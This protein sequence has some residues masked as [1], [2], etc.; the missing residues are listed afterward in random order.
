LKISFGSNL[1]VLI[2]L[3]CSSTFISGQTDAEAR[4]AQ[5]SQALVKGHVA[6]ETKLSSP[7][8]FAKAKQTG[9][10][11]SA[12]T[13][14][15]FVSGLPTDEVYT[16]MSW[17]V[18]EAKPLTVMRGVSIGKSGELMCAGRSPEQC[19][20]PSKKDD[21]IDFTFNPAKGEP[22]RLAF[23]AADHRVA[24]II[25]PDPIL[26]KDKGC[27]LNV[28]R[29]LPH[30]ELAYF[31]GSGFAPNSDASF[32]G[33]SYGEKHTV[34][35]KADSDGNIQFAIQP[36]VSGHSKGTTTLK[37]VGMGCSPSIKFD[38]GS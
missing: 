15:V 5:A 37:G 11:G 9:R 34:K 6:W 18:G 26:A 29:L 31:T 10:D 35:T 32:D 2:L 7:G 36:F 20:D 17:P 24:F 8:A 3:I 4:A 22:Y 25:V 23:V 38:W 16:Y 12:V 30:F 19:G 13:Y 33:E 27:T 14:S 28:E 21:P 1:N